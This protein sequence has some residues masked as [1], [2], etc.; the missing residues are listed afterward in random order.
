MDAGDDRPTARTARA[1]GGSRLSRRLDCDLGHDTEERAGQRPVAAIAGK[2]PGSRTGA[3]DGIAAHLRPVGGRRRQGG[4]GP[5]V[6][7][8]MRGSCNPSVFRYIWFSYIETQSEPSC[9]THIITT[10]TIITAMGGASPAASTGWVVL[11]PA[12]AGMAGP[13]AG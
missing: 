8:G 9:D 1:A 7:S 10:G 11:F 5:P 12:T 4:A 6:F 3:Q 2:R 13:V